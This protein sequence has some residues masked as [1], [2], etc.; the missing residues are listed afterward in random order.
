MGGDD[1][2]GLGVLVDESGG[3]L[4]VLEAQVLALQPVGYHAAGSGLQYCNT[5]TRC[6]NYI[7][8]CLQ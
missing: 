2:V 3:G 8:S 7:F 1:E 6:K 5:G 4:Q